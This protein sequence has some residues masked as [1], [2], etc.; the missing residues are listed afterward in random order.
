MA[1]VIVM[2]IE[3]ETARVMAKAILA[4]RADASKL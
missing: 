3:K 4:S 2:V 1:M